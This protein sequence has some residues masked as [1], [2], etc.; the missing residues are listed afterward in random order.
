MVKWITRDVK[1]IPGLLLSA[2][3]I[4]VDKNWGG[5]NITNLGAGGH[6]VNS[7]LNLV[8]AHKARHGLG[9]ADEVS[10]DAGQITSGRFGMARMPDGTSEYVLTAQGVGVDPTYA[11]APVPTGNDILEKL[12][13]H[14]GVWWFNNHWLPSGMLK[15]LTGG[16]GSIAWGDFYIRL[17]TGTTSSSYAY[18]DKHALGLSGGRTWDKKRYFGVYVYFY[19]YSAQ[20]I[21]I[22]SGDLSYTSSVNTNPHVGFKLINA[23]LYGTVGNG[24]AESTLLIET[25]TTVV[26]R[27]LECILDPTIPECRFYVDGVDK[28]AL[29]T[30]LPSGTS[31]AHRLLAASA[32]NTEAVDKY[33][34][35]YEVRIFQEE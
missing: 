23:N 28:G 10:L 27:R 24:T 14:L 13:K 22:L 4:D 11:P 20:Y 7:R 29:T 30:N 17:R 9:G 8:L 18:V 32:Y 21:H 12:Q 33:F 1:L 6:D 34:N 5:K 31:Y 25:I 19:T 15:S 3:S 2:L 35:I 26:N 16:S